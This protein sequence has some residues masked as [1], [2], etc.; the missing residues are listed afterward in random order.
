MNSKSTKSASSSSHM[1]Y[2]RK[3]MTRLAASEECKVAGNYKKAV[4]IAEE[5]LM[6]APNCL[7][8]IEE[9]AD[10]FLSL[11]NYEAAEKAAD[12]A[13][14][15]DEQSYIANYTKGFLALS[16][17]KWKPAV[18]FLRIANAGQPHNPEI[19]RCLGWGLFHVGK[20]ADG[21]VTLDR[22][23]N[24]RPHDPMILCDLGVCCL[25][26]NLFERAVSLFERALQVAPHNERAA[27]C[28]QAAKDIQRKFLV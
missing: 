28:L 14:S 7:A 8:A 20:Q 17:G 24:L 6:E 10:N 27:E 9:L 16:Q 26:S 18:A 13:L 3:I 15:I 1:P 21:M 25:Q 5:I 2:S 23:L 12:Y 4:Q 19:L 11:E 22:A